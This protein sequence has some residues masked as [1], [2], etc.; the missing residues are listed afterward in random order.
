M[1]SA[2]SSVVANI[3]AN[4]SAAEQQGL[5]PVVSQGVPSRAEPSEFHCLVTTY[6]IGAAQVDDFHNSSQKGR[7]TK[8]LLTEVFQMMQ[9]CHVIFFLQE[10]ARTWSTILDE[11]L[12]DGWMQRWSP[13]MTVALLF[14]LGDWASHV[15]RWW[16]NC[17]EVKH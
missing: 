13:R 11:H 4:I 14:K 16:R 17:L 12:P 5:V 8:K 1:A 10:I 6:N 2:S 9:K 15:Y 3:M 7:F